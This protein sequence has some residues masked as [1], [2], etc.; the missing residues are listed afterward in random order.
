MDLTFEAVRS[1]FA[2][3]P[4]KATPSASV[5]AKRSPKSLARFLIVAVFLMVIGLMVSYGQDWL[6]YYGYTLS[7]FAAPILYLIWMVRN[8]RYERE[9]LTLVI[10]T[11]GWGAFCA[12]FA[13]L[14]NI[15]FAV[16]LFGLLGAAFVEEPLKLLGVYWIARHHSVGSEFNDHLDGMIY[17]AAAG[18]GFAG[19]E[20]LSYIM[21]MIISGGIPP[22][23]AIAVRSATSF[24]H[25][26]WSAMAG[27]SLGLAKAL[28][29]RTRR[30]DLIPGLAVAVPLHFIWNLLSPAVSLFILL[31]LN[32]VVLVRLVRT[33]L[34]DELRWGFQ[35]S[36]PLE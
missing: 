11:F 35:S 29:G 28:N 36:A 20:N 16:P 14:F 7:G 24:C 17:G 33:A 32:L 19:L 10:L 22:L 8:D 2:S 4:V 18:A 31:P 13:A 6:S 25:I 34:R 1:L 23:L 5:Y 21:E 12:I 27:R 26:A 3:S 9:P 30:A 15:I